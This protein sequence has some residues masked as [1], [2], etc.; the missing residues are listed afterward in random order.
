MLEKLSIKAALLLVTVNNLYGYGFIAIAVIPFYPGALRRFSAKKVRLHLLFIALWII[1]KHF[2]ASGVAFG[3][4][5][6]CCNQLLLR[7]CSRRARLIRKVYLSHK[8]RVQY[9]LIWRSKD[10]PFIVEMELRALLWRYECRLACFCQRSACPCSLITEV[11]YR[12]LKVMW[13]LDSR[14]S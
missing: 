6:S 4:G 1:P 12:V 5:S 14:V 8:W 11:D 13:F 2:P 7:C 3:T 9:Y 10:L